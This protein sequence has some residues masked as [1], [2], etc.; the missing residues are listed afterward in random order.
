[1]VRSLHWKH[2]NPATN[3]SSIGRIDV[4][5][6][7][8]LPIFLIVIVVSLSIFFYSSYQSPPAQETPQ[9]PPAEDAPVTIVSVS[10]VL[11]G[12]N[13]SMITVQYKTD[14]NMTRDFGSNEA[15]LIVQ[16]SGKRLD[17]QWVTYIGPLASKS[18]GKTSGWFVIDNAER[19]VRNGTLVTIVIGDSRMEDYPVVG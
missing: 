8:L 4:K 16:S 3:T 6:K 2:R 14:R 18:A 5:K 13:G 11:G 15:Y 17:V 10:A 19:E 9:N 12:D 1:M 7:T